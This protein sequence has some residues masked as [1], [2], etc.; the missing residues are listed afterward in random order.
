VA[1]GEKLYPLLNKHGP[2]GN[3]PTA[4]IHQSP[5]SNDTVKTNLV[6]PCRVLVL[7][8]LSCTVKAGEALSR[9]RGAGHI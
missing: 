9:N 6:A 1:A 2:L 8:I 3:V 5:L 4:H 7:K